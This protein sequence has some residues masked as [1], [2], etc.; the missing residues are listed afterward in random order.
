MFFHPDKYTSSSLSRFLVLTSTLLSLLDLE[1]ICILPIKIH[2]LTLQPSFL[3]CFL[4][5]VKWREEDVVVTDL[6]VSSIRSS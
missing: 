5:V 3:D 4:E 1:A 2:D 6:G